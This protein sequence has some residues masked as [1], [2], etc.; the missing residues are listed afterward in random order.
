MAL[1]ESGVCAEP[2]WASS[3]CHNLKI[4]HSNM[5]RYNL[6]TQALLKG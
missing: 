1:F 3:Q 5:L 4:P 6:N 2:V